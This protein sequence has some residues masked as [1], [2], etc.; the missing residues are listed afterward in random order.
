VFNL[1]RIGIVATCNPGG[2]APANAKR[3]KWRVEYNEMLRGADVVILPDNDA[4]GYTHAT[5]IAVMTSGT[6]KRVRTLALAQH[7]PECPVGGDVSDW[8]RAGHTREELDALIAQAPEWQPPAADQ[9]TDEAKA[10]AEAQEQQ[11]IDELARLRPFDYERRRGDAARD[12]GIRHG[13]LDD[14]VEYRRQEQR[15][16]VALFGHWVVEPWP[17]PVDVGAL[18]SDIVRRIKKHVVLS[19]EAT[20]ATALWVLLAWVHADVAVHSPILWITS[21]E[22]DSG[23]TTLAVLVGFMTPRGLV[24]TEI[25]EAALFRSIELWT[26]TIVATEADAI[27]VNNEALRAVLNSGWTRGAGVLR[28]VGDDKVPHLFPTFAP[29]V[30]DM[31]GRRLPPSTMSRCIKVELRRKLDTESRDDFDHIDDIGLQE[32]RSRALRWALDSA[33]D[34]KSVR[35]ALDGFNNRLRQNWRLQVAIADLAGGD[36][37]DRARE[38]VLRLARVTRREAISDRIRAVIDI[39]AILEPTVEDGEPGAP[40]DAISSAKLVELLVADPDGFWAE[41]P[42]D[43]PLTQRRLA[44]LLE[45]FHIFPAQVW[46]TPKVQ[47]RGYLRAWFQDA[48]KRYL[49]KS[50]DNQ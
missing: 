48:W 27:L 19:D 6:A 8:L 12:L 44:M 14:A 21:A 22:P 3:P 50:E 24:V 29:K 18:I 9:Q 39:H 4:P 17:E 2:A 7:W 11:L 26:P 37:G 49:P 25:S 20:L 30:I 32:L 1:A 38:A 36:W 47:A 13:A 46:I 16:A 31:L 45:P 35:P 10:Q 40:I 28:C 23:K 33:D 5:A 43:K 41:Y 34:L 42:K 15:A